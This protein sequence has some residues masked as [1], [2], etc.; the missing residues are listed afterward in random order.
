MT[1]HHTDPVEGNIETHPVRLA[2]TIG[3]GAVVLIIA[4]VLLASFAV[5]THEVGADSKATSPAETAMRIAPIATLVVEDARAPASVSVAPAAAAPVN[6]ATAALPARIAAATP[7]ATPAAAMPDGKATYSQTCSVCHGTGIAGAPKFGDKAA[8]APR[9]AQG[10]AIL[11]DHAIKGYQGKVGM[12]PAK[13]GN[14]A[15][16]DADVKAAADYMVS[17]AK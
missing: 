6:T 17:Q 16:G 3:G 11:H 15:L 13:G 9:I 2:V 7:A 5:G 8:W 4:I 14:T 10:G 12:M 1:Q